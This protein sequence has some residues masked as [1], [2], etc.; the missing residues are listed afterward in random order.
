MAV[1]TIR[2]IARLL[3]C[4]L[5]DWKGHAHTCSVFPSPGDTLCIA[6]DV[7]CV[8]LIWPSTEVHV[9]LTLCV[10]KCDGIP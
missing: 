8:A 4:R 3:K 5:T 2:P 10:S 1:D 9:Y 6:W 7:V